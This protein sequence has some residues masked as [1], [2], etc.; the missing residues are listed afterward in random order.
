MEDERTEC[1]AINDRATAKVR[2][3]NKKIK[4]LQKIKKTLLDLQS[5]CPKKGPIEQCPIVGEIKARNQPQI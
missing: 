1:D 5:K 3:I 2:I 4:A